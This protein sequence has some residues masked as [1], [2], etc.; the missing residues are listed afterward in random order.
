[1]QSDDWDTLATQSLAQFQWQ[2]ARVVELAEEE[3]SDF[4]R[5]VPDFRPEDAGAGPGRART[6]G[7]AWAWRT[8]CWK[9]QRS[10]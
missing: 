8:S 9:T 7:E 6:A 3:Q 2:V 4:L 5:G 1:M 10:P